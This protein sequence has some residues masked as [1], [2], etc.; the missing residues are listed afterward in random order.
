MNQSLKKVFRTWIW[1]SFA[2]V[3]VTSVGGL[4]L[5]AKGW[6]VN[7]L[8]SVGSIF[9]GFGISLYLIRNH[10]EDK[11][12]K[13]RLIA[14]N[15]LVM[16]LS[17]ILHEILLAFKNLFPER[18][19]DIPELF[20]AP[21]DLTDYLIKYLPEVRKILQTSENHFAYNLELNKYSIIKNNV[22]EIISDITPQL[23]QSHTSQDLINA[24]YQLKQYYSFLEALLEA[25]LMFMPN[26][27][28]DNFIQILSSLW[29][30]S[31][32]ELDSIRQSNSK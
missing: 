3:V 2:V 30:L 17:F 19:D 21:L 32:K 9:I 24:L 28:L 7:M 10:E 31:N 22:V 4:Y 14:L 15:N 18:F 12:T 23:I 25:K 1:V 8:A 26:V 29:Y 20:H 13:V 27:T 11:W 5:D 16:E 6:L